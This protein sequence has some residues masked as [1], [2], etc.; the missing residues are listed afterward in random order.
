VL[1]E[2]IEKL[3][4]NRYVDFIDFDADARD[5]DDRRSSGLSLT[6]SVHGCTLVAAVKAFKSVV[7]T[8]GAATTSPCA[9]G[10]R[11]LAARFRKIF[12]RQVYAA[13]CGADDPDRP[14]FRRAR[15][16]G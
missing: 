7:T 3:W 15:E 1:A 8:R 16:W 12:L 5:V 6:R 11:S 4:T 2:K 9:N 10:Y 13:L 14:H